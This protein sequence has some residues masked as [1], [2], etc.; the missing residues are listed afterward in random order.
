MAMKDFYIV[1]NVLVKYV[2]ADTDVVVPGGVKT[3][4]RQAFTCRDTLTS[5]VL[6]DGVVTIGEQ[7][8]DSC[9]N[10][11]TVVI[12]ASVTKIEKGA[13]AA[14][15]SL[16]SV[17][18]PEGVPA[19]A[20]RAFVGCFS[21]KEIDIPASVTSIGEYAFNRCYNLEKIIIGDAV[22]EIGEEA[23]SY[24]R[25]LK[26]VV[27]G[28]GIAKI[29]WNTFACCESLTTV[30]FSVG[31][32]EIVYAAFDGCHAISSVNFSGTET[33]WRRVLVSP[34]KNT[35]ILSAKM[36]YD[37]LPPKVQKAKTPTL[38]FD[39]NESAD[40][41]IG[42]DAEAAAKEEQAKAEVEVEENASQAVKV[43]ETVS[44][45]NMLSTAEGEEKEAPAT[46]D[47]VSFVEASPVAPVAPVTAERQAAESDTTV[48]EAPQGIEKDAKTEEKKASTPTTP[49]R[50]RPTHTAQTV[51]DEA[52]KQKFYENFIATMSSETA[53]QQERRAAA[54]TEE[55]FET[56]SE[57][58]F[59][60]PPEDAYAF[61]CMCLLMKRYN[62]AFRAFLSAA[63]KGN[64]PS[65]FYVGCCFL[66]GIDTSRKIVDA[67]RWLTKCKGD[68]VFG[69][70]A[71]KALAI[72]DEELEKPE[73]AGLKV[74]RG[75]K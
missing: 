13:F 52:F 11:K 63:G 8:F 75:N 35:S 69:E 10:L 24:C 30:Y 43:G 57:A 48:L 50:R 60:V 47:N 7:A 26:T 25:S 65:Q 41:S 54:M 67:A 18:I 72:V 1:D 22:T 12:P 45:L 40:V 27:L 49:S 51:A 59:L 15:R 9:Y 5:V 20:T 53:A 39:L 71:L 33:E 42:I 29:Q 55:E 64:L 58:L 16:T 66:W 68:P 61:G 62:W 44:L 4:G 19:I 73:N 38:S 37:S 17:K 31:L 32:R 21:L 6:P 70:D 2:G 28:R 46:D 14:C 36:F 74:K 23:F 3:I 34:T 56:L